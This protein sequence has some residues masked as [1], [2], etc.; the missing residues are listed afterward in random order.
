MRL[1]GRGDGRE[2]IS[3]FGNPMDALGHFVLVL[4]WAIFPLS[5]L[6]ATAL[7]RLIAG[8]SGWYL[9]VCST[10]PIAA[11]LL[12]SD[13]SL[14]SVTACCLYVLVGFGTMYLLDRLEYRKKLAIT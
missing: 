7:A 10:L 6:L 9:A 4:T 1:A 2:L 14:T 8:R 5:V 11:I 12:L 3:R 13:V